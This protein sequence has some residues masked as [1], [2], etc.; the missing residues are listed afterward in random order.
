MFIRPREAQ[1]A[2]EGKQDCEFTGNITGPIAALCVI[3]HACAAMTAAI[4]AG[5]ATP[6]ACRSPEKA[7]KYSQSAEKG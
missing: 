2:V 6:G 4:G 5:Q 7:V 3:R 1:K